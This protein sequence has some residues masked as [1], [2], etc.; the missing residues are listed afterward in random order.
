MIGERAF[1]GADRPQPFGAQYTLCRGAVKAQNRP[2]L[3]TETRS[4]RRSVIS[5][6][7][8]G[9]K[10]QRNMN[11]ISLLLVT[12]IFC[13][14]CVAT[15]TDLRELADD[16]RNDRTTLADGL[17]D[18]ADELDART[19]ATQDGM[20]SLQDGGL[21]GGAATLLAFLGTNAARDRKRKQRGER[22][23]TDAPA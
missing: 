8:R 2:E 19:K 18:L 21:I 12:A 1:R 11:R 17:D 10:L 7:A 22:V 20:L 15:S 5:R 13:C 3:D 23:G 14:G 16:V 4:I 6:S 9:C